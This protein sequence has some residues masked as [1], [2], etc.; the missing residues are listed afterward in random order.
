MESQVK[1]LHEGVARFPQALL[2]VR[3]IQQSVDCFRQGCGT[4]RGHYWGNHAS[5]RQH[6]IRLMGAGGDGGAARGPASPA[7]NHS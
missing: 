6:P 1:G 3:M 4:A 2:F 7:G 5:V